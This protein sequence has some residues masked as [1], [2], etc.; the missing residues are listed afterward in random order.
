MRKIFIICFTLILSSF[1][2]VEKSQEKDVLSIICKGKWLFESATLAG[3][4]RDFPKEIQKENWMVFHKDGRH[5]VKT[6]GFI[7]NGTWEYDKENK[8]FTFVDATGE[9]AIQKIK[10]ITYKQ[11][12]LEG[13]LD[14]M[15]FSIA[16]IK[17]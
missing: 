4:K 7:S 12:M 17:R 9:T 2:I 10:K 14:G 5:E 11:L 16:L 6:G 8:S 15:D 3:D 1:T 13:K